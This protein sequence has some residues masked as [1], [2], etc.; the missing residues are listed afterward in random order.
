MAG[1]PAPA[2]LNSRSSRPNVF[3]V[4]AKQ[5]FHLVGLADIGRPRSSDS[6]PAGRRLSPV[7]LVVR[8]H[9]GV[10]G[11]VERQGHS[12][13]DAASGAGDKRVVY[14][15]PVYSASLGQCIYF[16]SNLKSL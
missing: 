10:P 16:L 13:P 3:P 4:C 12:A 1:A 6:R 9:D 14:G 7:C 5:R 15:W 2:L 11:A 8:Q